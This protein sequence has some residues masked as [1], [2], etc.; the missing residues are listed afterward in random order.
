M[1]PLLTAVHLSWALP[2]Q[3]VY[4]DR[5]SP[6]PRG[7]ADWWYIGGFVSAVVELLT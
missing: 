3:K 2:Y 6:T 7:P 4:T 1:P 5:G